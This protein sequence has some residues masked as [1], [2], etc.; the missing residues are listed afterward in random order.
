MSADR[1][2]PRDVSPTSPA[3]LP[4]LVPLSEASGLCGGPGQLS[5]DEA[6]ELIQTYLDHA[7]DP[8]TGEKLTEHLGDCPPCEHEF[9]VYQRIVDALG[10]CRPDVPADTKQRLAQYCTSLC[11]GERQVEG[12]D[13]PTGAGD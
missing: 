10:R 13:R 4:P 8:D 9:V 6:N 7:V 11:E 1:P 12:A 3:G 2:Q 5:C